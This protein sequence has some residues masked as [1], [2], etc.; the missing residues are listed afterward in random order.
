MTQ[1]LSDAIDTRFE[2][3]GPPSP[4]RNLRLVEAN[5]EWE[6]ARVAD[7]ERALATVPES[8]RWATELGDGN[9]FPKRIKVADD[10]FAQLMGTDADRSVVLGGPSG[11]GK[12]SVAVAIWARR[13][14]QGPRRGSE[15]FVS[16]LDLA[17]SYD[18][19]HRRE[20]GYGE[21]VDRAIAA[22]QLVIDDL[23]FETV[24]SFAK[25][26]GAV[27][28]ERHQRRRPT[29]VTTSLDRAGLVAAYG[30]GVVRRMIECA[31][32]EKL[33]R[34]DGGGVG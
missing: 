9:A 32:V 33:V 20:P 2:F 22:P 31:V 6:A 23:G 14:R 11:V 15:L 10:V 17:K 3:E 4:F 25:V 28:Y 18:T 16:S 21:L 30:G 19:H 1:R 13:V 24:T 8:F 29:I 5:A 27:I 7:V 34:R 12:T 26:A